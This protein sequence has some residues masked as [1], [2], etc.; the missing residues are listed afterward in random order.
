MKRIEHNVFVEAATIPIW[1]LGAQ[2]RRERSQEKIRNRAEAFI[3]EIG[4]DRV[5]SVSE[6]VPTFGRFSLVVWWYREFT[7][8]DTPVVRAMEEHQSQ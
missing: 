5:V 3:N 2:A 7:E 4:A 1:S 8:A 6:H